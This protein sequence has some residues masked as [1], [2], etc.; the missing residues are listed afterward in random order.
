MSAVDV[1]EPDGYAED[2]RYAGEVVG[3]GDAHVLVMEDVAACLFVL[4]RLEDG[5]N[6][7]KLFV[8]KQVG[9]M[10]GAQLKR[11]ETATPRNRATANA[12]RLSKD[13]VA[14]AIEGRIDGGIASNE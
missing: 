11:A 13:A 5:T 6:M 3:D 7:K 1:E 12:G 2:S 14:N 10:T 8:E 4:V 9:Q